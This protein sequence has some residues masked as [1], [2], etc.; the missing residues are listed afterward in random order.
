MNRPISPTSATASA[1]SARRSGS[2]PLPV[3]ARRSLSHT[4][5]H[6]A[7]TLNRRSSAFSAAE[8]GHD[9]AAS[10]DNAIGE[11]IDEI[12]RYED[13]TTID[14][15]RDAERE[16][17]R[18]RSRRQ[19]QLGFFKRQGGIGW[20]RKL[21]ESYDAGQAWLVVT[22]I[23]ATIGLN[24]A[25]LN[26]VTEWLSDI[27]LGYCTTAFYLNEEFCCWGAEGGETERYCYSTEI[28]C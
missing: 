24:A 22:I 6:R 27:K 16:A 20:R 25:F 2:V 5:A 9:S 28:F 10:A 14:W 23:G 11:E 21:W 1:P 15:V 8:Q 18:R 3:N 26:I 19:E 12:K 17:Q 4:F 13:F 7:S